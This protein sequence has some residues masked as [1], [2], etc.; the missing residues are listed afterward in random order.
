MH[1]TS[2]L[3]YQTVFQV[4]GL[5]PVIVTDSNTGY[6]YTEDGVGGASLIAIDT[7]SYQVVATLQVP[8]AVASGA[9][10]APATL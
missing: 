3:A 8:K 9:D 5:S 10:F 4:R 6:T 7:T 2:K 1:G